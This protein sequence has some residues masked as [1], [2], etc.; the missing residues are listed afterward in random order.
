MNVHPIIR[1]IVDR[2]HIGQSNRSVIYAVIAQL[3][4]GLSQDAI[5]VEINNRLYLV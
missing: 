1:Q 2:Q 4:E 5:A 3:K